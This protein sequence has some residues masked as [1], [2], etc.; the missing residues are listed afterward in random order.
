MRKS[1]SGVKVTAELQTPSKQDGLV[2]ELER[3]GDEA[4]DEDLKPG[5]T[6][7]RTLRHELKEEGAHVLSVTVSYTETLRGQD[8]SAATA[9]RSRT[10][11]KLY[12]FAS[13]QLLAVRSKITER[14]IQE[15]DAS[16]QWI[17][18]AQLENV[19]EAS[20]ALEKVWL[21]EGDGIKSVDMNADTGIDAIVLKPQDV[22]QVMFLLRQESPPEDLESRVPLAQIKIDWRSAMGEMGSITTHWLTSRGR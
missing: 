10:F 6:L 21:T 1:V 3:S 11:R 22:E 16:R 9:G 18:Q 19:G 5:S 15:D 14:K 8:G 20:V 13:Q 2:L 17:L 12:Q 4:E 7:Q